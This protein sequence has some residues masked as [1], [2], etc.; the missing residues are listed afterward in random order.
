MREK[1]SESTDSHLFFPSLSLFLIPS[2]SSFFPSSSFTFST[3][4]EEGKGTR[5]LE[6]KEGERKKSEKRKQREGERKR[7][8]YEEAN[9]FALI[10]CVVW[11]RV[12]ERDER[13]S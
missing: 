3:L 13:E 1:E 12:S 9:F 11:S 7:Y 2:S 5:K 6:E 8:F 10:E 4:K